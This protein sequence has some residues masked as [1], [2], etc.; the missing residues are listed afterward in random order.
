MITST[1][2]QYAWGTQADYLTQKALAANALRKIIVQDSNFVDFAPEVRND[3]GWAHGKNRPT[4]QWI[5]AIRAQSV[6]H[7]MVGWLEEIG[8]VAKLVMGGYAVTTPGGGTVSR[9]HKMTPQDPAVSRQ[10]QAVTYWEKLG[11]SDNLFRGVLGQSFGLSGD[12]M[13][14]LQLDF[15]LQPSGKVTYPSGVNPATHVVSPADVSVA[16]SGLHKLY[17]TQI[18]LVV[19]DGVTPVTYGCKYRKFALNYENTFFMEA[20][21]KPGCGNFQTNGDKTSGAVMSELL[22]DQQN[23]SFSFEVDMAED[24]GELDAVMKQ[25][26]MEIVTTISDGTIIEAAIAR[27]LE[28]NIPKTYYTARKLG[29]GGGIWRMMI[30]A[31]V[32]YDSVSNKTLEMTAV[33]DI[34][35]YATW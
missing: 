17:N 9:S 28:I 21:Y 26:P 22:F 13:G 34:A 5:E 1:E 7:S 20:G 18:A 8:R 33:N 10:L 29:E 30:E 11:I 23:I 4:E 16:P 3:Q 15:A 25:K 32:F 12:A 19:D 6:S 24:S 35:T 27:S 14:A 31:N 2:R